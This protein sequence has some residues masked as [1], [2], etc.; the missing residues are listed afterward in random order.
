MHIKV[1]GCWA[2]DFGV[3][4]HRL[5]PRLWDGSIGPNDR[6]RLVKQ[7]GDPVLPLL[8]RAI[9]QARVGEMLVHS[10]ALGCTERFGV[11]RNGDGFDK[12][13][14]MSQHPT[15]VKFGRWYRNH[16]NR[17]PDISYGRVIASD[18]TPM[19]RIELVNALF[20]TKEAAQAGGG[21]V[22]DKELEELSRGND[23]STS[24]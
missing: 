14:C 23:I 15:F 13:T 22:A 7:A 24:M 21:L 8:K 11:N 10:I 17:N 19:G 4:N 1:S 12:Q 18:F 6:R 2:Q 16:M 3:P 5:V 9:E 20:G